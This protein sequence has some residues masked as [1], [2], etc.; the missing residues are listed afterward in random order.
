MVGI[1]LTSPPNSASQP[2]TPSAAIWPFSNRSSPVLAT[3]STSSENP[4]ELYRRAA[5]LTLEQIDKSDTALSAAIEALLLWRDNNWQEIEDQL[6]EMLKSRDRWM[7][8]FVLKGEQDWEV[9]RK[10]LEHPFARAAAHDSFPLRYTD[11]DWQIVRACFTLLR[12]A[13]AQLRVV[14]AE[15]GAVDYTE[16]A[17]IAFSVLRGHDGLPTDAALSVADGIHHILVDEF[18]DTSRRQHDLLRRLIAAWP[19]REGRSCFVVGDPMQSI[20]FFRDADA[21]LFPRVQ[22]AGLEIPN[23]EPLIFDSV[24][25]TSNFRTAKPLVLELNE[26]FERVFAEDDGSGVTFS[27]AEPAR[28]DQTTR[29]HFELHINFVPQA[30]RGKSTAADVDDERDAPRT[31]QID[32]I[33]ALIQSHIGPHGTLLAQKVRNIAS[34]C[35]AEPAT[36][37]LP[38]PRPS[39]IADIPFRAVD[40]EK[41]S[42]RPEVLDALALA[43][44]LLNPLDRVSW[45]G[46]LR[47]PWCGLSLSDLHILTSADDPA[48][49]ARP[50]PELL[51]ERIA[52][53]SEEGRRAAE[54]LLEVLADV[55]AMRFAQPT[56]VPRH[57]APASLAA[58]R[59]RGL[60]RPHR[61]RQSRP[62]LAM[63]R[64]SSQRRTGPA[65]PH[66]RSSP[67]KPDRAARP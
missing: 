19:E 62:P 66:P 29:R 41:L 17:Q 12:H 59:R 54:R 8:D 11:E 56:T 36:P 40:L 44:A 38:S 35:S 61:P 34:P 4:A 67:R 32:E 47:A 63:P 65:R 58:P 18:Q 31:A 14:F 37:S 21:E 53:L 57:L 20:Y 1:C 42:T 2:L 23:S 10:R 5:R 49:L 9:L 22:I 3:V 45:L 33:V 26:I 60:R 48:L 46:V 28:E 25:L 39:A 24:G 6:V 16:V 64:Q 7:Q 15:A 27:P 52:L 43:R 51:A 30:A 55:P 13:A 50:I